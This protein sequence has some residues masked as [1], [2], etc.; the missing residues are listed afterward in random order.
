MFDG[1]YAVNNMP[2]NQRF[3]RSCPE[4]HMFFSI[5]PVDIRVK[6]VNSPFHH[7]FSTFVA[8]FLS[9]AKGNCILLQALEAA[10]LQ[11]D[12]ICY[13]GVISACAKGGA[14]AARCAIMMESCGYTLQC[15][16][17]KMGNP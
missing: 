6:R 17:L 16:F 4:E 2:E 1:C 11:P 7:G 3:L 12:V 14:W 13:S 5:S 8:F 15:W 9:L 10:E